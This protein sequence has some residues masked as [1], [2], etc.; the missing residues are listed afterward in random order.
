MSTTTKLPTTVAN[1][2]AAYNYGRI[3]ALE[4]APDS[5]FSGRPNGSPDENEVWTQIREAYLAG[6]RNQSSR[7]IAPAQM[8]TP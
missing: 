1:H 6:Y 7:L 5:R 4:G 3:D 2:L 8:E